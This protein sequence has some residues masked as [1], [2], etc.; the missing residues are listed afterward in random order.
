MKPQYLNKTG[1]E[2]HKVHTWR[3][4]KAVNIDPKLLKQNISKQ[5][6]EFYYNTI[7]K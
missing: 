3:A 6:S 2:Y 7:S 5:N 4:I 1:K